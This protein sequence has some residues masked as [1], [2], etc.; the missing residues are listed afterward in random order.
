MLRVP[1]VVILKRELVS[2][3]TSK[4]TA[5][6]VIPESGLVQEG[7]QMTPTRVEM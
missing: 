5:T 7:L 1:V 2:L 3:V 4:I 6:A